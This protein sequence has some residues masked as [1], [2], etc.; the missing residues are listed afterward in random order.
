MPAGYGVGNHWLFVVDFLTSSVIGHSP[1]SII[2]SA[3][4]RLNTKIPGTGK[5]YSDRLDTLLEGH[6]LSN[7]LISAHNCSAVKEIVKEQVDKIDDESKQYMRCAEKKCRRIKS[8]KIPFSPE[9][10][11]WIRRCQVY[12]PILRFHAGKIRNRANLKRS[13]R[14]CGIRRP[15]SL[16]LQE[17]RE[18]L[19]NAK[20]KCAYFQRHGQRYRQ[21]HL[22]KRLM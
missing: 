6:S 20:K 15:L 2:R 8:G 14:Q 19:R 16:S 10:S 21:K 17:L 12:R 4:R 3:A 1:P 22:N 11:L 18:R 5:A 13:A 7:K 9:S